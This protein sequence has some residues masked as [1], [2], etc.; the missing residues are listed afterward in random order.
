MVQA[1]ALLVGQP[2][3]QEEEQLSVEQSH[4]QQTP[5]SLE[6]L[7]EAQGQELTFG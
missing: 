2:E 3:A 4:Q 7:M 5:P 1:A 6:S